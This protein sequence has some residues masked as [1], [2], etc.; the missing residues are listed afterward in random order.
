M[1]PL[2]YNSFFLVRSEAQERLK[3]TTDI[4]EKTKDTVSHFLNSKKHILLVAQWDTNVNLCHL[5]DKAMKSINSRCGHNDSYESFTLYRRIVP[6]LNETL[7]NVLEIENK[8]VIA[9]VV[10]DVL[11][12]IFQTVFDEAIAKPRPSVMFPFS[13]IHIHKYNET[14]SPTMAHLHL[15]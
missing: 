13:P 12:G 14:P 1:S 3:E 6:T 8:I 15:S 7:K 11:D 5:F 4:L 9:K 2:L 10:D